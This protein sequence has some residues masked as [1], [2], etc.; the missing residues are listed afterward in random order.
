MLDRLWWR[1]HYVS[2]AT[3]TCAALRDLSDPSQRL[4]SPAVSL[5]P[6]RPLQNLEKLGYKPE[7]C[8]QF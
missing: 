1:G 5:L 3:G 7:Q 2:Q 4:S 8:I 6:V